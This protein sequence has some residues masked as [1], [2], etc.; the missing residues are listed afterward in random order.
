VTPIRNERDL[1]ASSVVKAVWDCTGRALYFSRSVI[2]FVR[3]ND[4]GAAGILHWRH[5]GVYAY[6]R[7]FLAR[8][9]KAPPCLLERAEKLEQLRALHIGG[10]IAILE[11]NE[12]GIGVDTP[13]DVQYVESI[14]AGR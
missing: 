13:A 12:A 5:L 6:T 14:L 1:N 7:S 4:M 8:L 10:R 2:P 3:D 11:V 9:V